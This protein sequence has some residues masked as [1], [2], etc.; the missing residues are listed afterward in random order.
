[1]LCR[2]LSLI[3]IDLGLNSDPIAPAD[4]AAVATFADDLIRRRRPLRFAVTTSVWP[5]L[6]AACHLQSA[7]TGNDL[8]APRFLKNQMQSATG[9][10]WRWRV[11]APRIW[12]A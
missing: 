12:S 8:P 4:T 2:A 11:T 10:G 1:M 7:I 3:A 5:A 9:D 6:V